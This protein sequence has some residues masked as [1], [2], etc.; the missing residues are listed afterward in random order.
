[1]SIQKTFL[2][3]PLMFDPSCE[4]NQEGFIPDFQKKYEPPKNLLGL[5]LREKKTKKV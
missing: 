5:T 3:Y 1:M 2:V 4:K